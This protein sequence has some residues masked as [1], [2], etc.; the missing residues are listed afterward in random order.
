MQ[1]YL[2]RGWAWALGL[3]AMLGA[4]VRAL[5]R[6]IRFREDPWVERGHA[7]VVAGGDGGGFLALFLGG[8]ARGAAVALA[9]VLLLVGAWALLGHD[10]AGGVAGLLLANTPAAAP[11]PKDLKGILAEVEQIQTAHKGKAMPPEVADR[12]EKLM[13]EG[14]VLQDSHDRDQAAAGLKR[15]AS[16]VPGGGTLPEDQPAPVAGKG[17]RNGVAGYI[18]VG[19]LA[20]RSEAL[21]KFI[22]VGMPKGAQVQIAAAPLAQ[23]VE[24][25]K[26]RMFVP[27]TKEGRE[28]IEQAEAK[29]FEA[30]KVEGKAVPTLGTGI[31]EPERLSELVRVTEQEQV[32]LMDVLNVSRTNSDAVT[33]PRLVSYTRAAAGVAVGVAKPEATLELEMVTEAVKTQA[34]WM[35]VHD[36]QLA[37]YPQLRNIIDTELLYDLRKLV[38]EEAMY[39]DGTGEHFEGIVDHPNVQ[40][41]R[42]EGGD[43][44]IDIIRRGIT[45]VRRAGYAPNAVVL[46]PLDWEE[47]ELE[48]GSD[49]RYVWAVIR[50]ALGPRIWSLR[51]V[52]TVGAEANEGNTTERRNLVVGDFVRGA[53]LWVRESANISVGW[54]NDQFVK[55]QRT[56]L[57]EQRAAFGVKRP[58]AFRVHETQAAVS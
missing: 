30:D 40:L 42:S 19:D 28:L 38:E 54:I 16:G 15:F 11:M 23:M 32:E 13:T 17:S 52:E 12:W 56:I 27:L 3:L 21:Q 47:I 50:D 1:K 25:G 34:V 14:K 57:A 4:P 45:D 55:N 36:R 22:A 6:I 43:T 24:R 26:G 35:P 51:V 7:K 31:I 5:P 37:D 58:N 10:G 9:L 29:L 48:K 2:S 39:G 53:T 8:A 33:Y 18:T 20:A 46:D 44:L 41:A 49:N